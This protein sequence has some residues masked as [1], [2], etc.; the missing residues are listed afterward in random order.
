MSNVKLTR[1]TVLAE[2]ILMNMMSLLPHPAPDVSII[3]IMLVIEIVNKTG[4]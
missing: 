4:V 1:A 3:I 2:C